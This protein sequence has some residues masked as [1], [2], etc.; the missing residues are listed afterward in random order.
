MLFS[1]RA[2]LL[3]AGKGQYIINDPLRGKV[4]WEIGDLGAGFVLADV[5]GFISYLC[6]EGLD[7]LFITL[8]FPGCG[9]AFL[10]R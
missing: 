7:I 6:S 2:F 5:M 4:N 10:E 1:V 3:G 8:A 9:T